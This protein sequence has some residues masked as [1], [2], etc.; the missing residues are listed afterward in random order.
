MAFLLKSEILCT[1]PL[2]FCNINRLIAVHLDHG[3]R[4]M[5]KAPEL[6]ATRMVEIPACSYSS[7]ARERN[8]VIGS[9]SGLTTFCINASLTIK[10][11]ADVS[12][13]SRNR[14]LPASMPS[15]IPAA[16]DVLPLASSVEND[17]YLSVWQIIDK[18]GNID[19]FDKPSV[20]RTKF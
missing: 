18:H 8:G 2:L 17:G 9:L 19:I 11:V 16:C 20:L 14:R 12:S 6:P 1:M 13:S 3:I 5:E 15:T 10:F 7:R 4:N